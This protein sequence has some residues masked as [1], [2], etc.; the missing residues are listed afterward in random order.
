MTPGEAAQLTAWLLIL[1][2]N[3]VLFIAS[4]LS[5]A[6]SWPIIAAFALNFFQPYCFLISVYYQRRTAHIFVST[7]FFIV[8]LLVA[9]DAF[10]QPAWL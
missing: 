5:R 4:L 8:N 3:I 10:E 1:T 6:T 7:A 9:L 2:Q